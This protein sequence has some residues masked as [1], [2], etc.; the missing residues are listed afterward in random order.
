[1]QFDNNAVP[2]EEKNTI[3]RRKVLEALG[4][5]IIAT[6]VIGCTSR[7][8]ATLAYDDE[9]TPELYHS[10]VRALASAIRS[11]DVS[12]CLLYTSDAADDL[13]PV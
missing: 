5:G 10:S 8:G 4:A 1:M 3:S 6:G 9:L 2:K 7:E 13:Q 12:S 11:G